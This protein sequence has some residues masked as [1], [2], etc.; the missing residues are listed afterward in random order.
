MRVP[1]WIVALFDFTMQNSDINS[2]LQDELI[3][4]RVDLEAQS[5]FKRKT[6]VTVPCKYRC[7]NRIKRQGSRG[8]FHCRVPMTYLMTSYFV[9]ITF[10]LIRNVLLCFLLQSRMYLLNCT[11]S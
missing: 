2:Q 5:L 4:M 1:D 3:D 9:T 10:S 7:Q 8:N 11:Y 6:C